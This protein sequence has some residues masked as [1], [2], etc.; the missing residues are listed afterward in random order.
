MAEPPR[1]APLV[2]N[3]GTIL[4]NNEDENPIPREEIN[5]KNNNENES[6]KNNDRPLALSDQISFNLFFWGA[7]LPPAYLDIVPPS[8]RFFS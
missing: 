4:Y 7:V 6:A 2:K 5:S 1:D 3:S 8:L